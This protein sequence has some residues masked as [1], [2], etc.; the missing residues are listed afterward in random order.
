L[1]PGVDYVQMLTSISGTDR[2]NKVDR[3]S[4]EGEVVE[5]VFEKLFC[6]I[7]C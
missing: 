4:T 2:S 1:N 6:T 7:C 5:E 3:R